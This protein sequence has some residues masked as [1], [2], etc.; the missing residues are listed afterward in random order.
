MCLAVPAKVL[1]IDGDHAMVEMGTLH[2][3]CYLSLVPEAKVGDYVII[4]A[5]Y[6]I[7]ILDQEEARI[8]LDLFRQ[9]EEVENA[10]NSVH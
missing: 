7:E 8:T 5:G 6:A 4:H 10:E 3:D 9:L 1:T 2:Q